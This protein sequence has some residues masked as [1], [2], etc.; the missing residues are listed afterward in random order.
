MAQMTTAA[1]RV[2]DPINSSVVRGFEH[3][4]HVGEALFP[5]VHVKTRGGK[6]I[7]FNRDSFRLYR[8]IRAPGAATPRVQFGYASAPFSVEDHSLEAAVPVELDQEAASIG[9]DMSEGPL[10]ELDNI[11]GLG[12]EKQRADIARTAASYAGSN[13][14]ALTGSD[15]FDTS[16][17]NP[18]SV[19]RVAREAVR[20]KIGMYPNVAL[21]PS[22]VFEAMCDHALARDQFKY[23][24]ADSVTP[25]MMARW[26]RI[27]KIVVGGSVFIDD[28]DVQQD[29][30][31]KDIVLAYVNVR[32]MSKRWMGSPSAFYTYNLAGYPLA[33]MPY[34]DRNAK[35]EIYP[36]THARTP[37]A[38]GLDAAYLIQAA[39]S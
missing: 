16:T 29:V 18:P 12:L 31:G 17:S 1:A 33:E 3:P 38:A 22:P 2:V 27:P 20:S 8:T 5:I 39:V 13:K 10:Y 19:F 37:V 32:P 25:E 23:T 9:I 21:I 30:W 15:R 36:V 7:Q 6:V 11:M 34:T 24:S 14:A 26:L 28:A 4:E 35:S